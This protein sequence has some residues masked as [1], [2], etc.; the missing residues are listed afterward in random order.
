MMMNMKG[1]KKPLLLL[2]LMLVS[3]FAKA[4]GKTPKL[5]LDLKNGTI[6]T[7][8]LSEC[9][10]VTFPDNRLAVTTA[11]FSYNDSISIADVR[12][13]RFFEDATLS[14]ISELPKEAYTIS[15]TDGQTVQLKGFGED[16]NIQIISTSGASQQVDS[17]VGGDDITLHLGHLP[18]GVYIIKVNDKSYKVRTK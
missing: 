7:F 13:M 16:A 11:D 4:D 3:L 8:E 18:K 10:K 6:L 5:F 1:V 15:F 2:G 9:P 17:T 12:T 14:D